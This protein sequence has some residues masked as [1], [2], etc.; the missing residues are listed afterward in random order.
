MR[1][2]GKRHPTP[3]SPRRRFRVFVDAEAVQGGRLGG[4]LSR[5]SPR[6]VCLLCLLSGMQLTLGHVL[7]CRVTGRRKR[8]PIELSTEVDGGWL[9]K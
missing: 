7:R 9:S 5:R 4:S 2:V 6:R 1:R 8:A 3:G